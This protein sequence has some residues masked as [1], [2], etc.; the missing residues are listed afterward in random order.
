MIYIKRND[1]NTY[2]VSVRTTS[3]LLNIIEGNDINYIN[4]DFVLEIEQLINPN[5]SSVYDTPYVT[6]NQTIT[7]VSSN[8]N[9]LLFTLS[10]FLDIDDN[11]KPIEELD[12]GQYKYTIKYL[13]GNKIPITVDEGIFLVDEVQL[14]RIVNVPNQEAKIPTP[15]TNP[16]RNTPTEETYITIHNIY[17]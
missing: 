1:T 13:L 7:N 3:S 16:T 14:D 17:K 4:T 9:Y 8:I 10:Y 11:I 15:I 2:V 6:Y 5:N 12:L